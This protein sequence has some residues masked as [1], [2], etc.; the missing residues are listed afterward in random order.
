MLLKYI[1]PKWRVNKHVFLR[2]QKKGNNR[3][4]K[5]C[6]KLK[7][8]HKCLMHYGCKVVNCNCYYLENHWLAHSVR[9]WGFLDQKSSNFDAIHFKKNTL[10]AFWKE[11]MFLLF[12]SIESLKENINMCPH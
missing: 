2:N 11:K 9:N 3:I 1:V 7:N 10:K 4:V 5:Y 6:I 12:I 8:V